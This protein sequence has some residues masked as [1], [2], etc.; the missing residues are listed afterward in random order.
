LNSGKQ[1]AT[2]ASGQIPSTHTV[3]KENIPTVKL[4]LSGKI[5]TEAA[6]AVTRNEQ[7]LG[8]RPRFRDWA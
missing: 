8:S 3:G 5:K 7:K 6:G 1:Q 4:I 2:I